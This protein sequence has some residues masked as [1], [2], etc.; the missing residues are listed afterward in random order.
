MT[1]ESITSLQCFS[2]PSTE[3][4]QLL[5][6]RLHRTRIECVVLPINLLLLLMNPTQAPKP[7]TYVFPTPHSP[8]ILWILS[9]YTVLWIP[10]FLSTFT[11]RRRGSDYHHLFPR[12][13]TD[14]E[15]CIFRTHRLVSRFQALAFAVVSL[16]DNPHRS[17]L[18]FRSRPC[19]PPRASFY[20]PSIFPVSLGIVCLDHFSNSSAYYSIQWM[21]NERMMNE[22]H[23]GARS[24]KA[25][26]RPQENPG[27]T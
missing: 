9:Q 15:W 14:S 6:E 27:R 8:Q 26:T 10:W 3:N 5:T 16:W 2:W 13:E 11:V 20:D 24:P 21:L 25:L 4:I 12:H 17:R 19:S 18:S 22:W 7:C 1:L 23:T